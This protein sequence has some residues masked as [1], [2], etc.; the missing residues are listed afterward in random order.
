[1]WFQNGTFAGPIFLIPMMMF[2]GFGVN[3]RDIP[4]YLKWGTH[5]SFFRYALEGYVESIYGFARRP[6]SCYAVM[7]YYKYPE[8]FLRSIAMDKIDIWFSMEMLMLTLILTKIVGY[9]VLS[10]KVKVGRWLSDYSYFF[11]SVT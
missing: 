7:C 10:W 9:Y 3:L 4:S 6:F 2:S 11:Q 5:I 8:F 1:M